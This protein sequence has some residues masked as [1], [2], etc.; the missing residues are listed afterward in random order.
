KSTRRGPPLQG[1]ASP[2][3]NGWINSDQPPQ[4]QD[5]ASA[6]QFSSVSFEFIARILGAHVLGAHAEEVI[7]LFA[8]AIRFNLTAAD[9]KSTLF[10]YPTMTAELAQLL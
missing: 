2:N 6:F 4:L 1:Q 5:I 7:N 3:K 10:A 8:L 9:F